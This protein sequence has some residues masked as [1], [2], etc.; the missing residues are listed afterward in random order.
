[1]NR[2]IYIQI[3]AAYCFVTMALF[4]YADH[5]KL[6]EFKQHY[7]YA[8]VKLTA[9]LMSTGIWSSLTGA[10]KTVWKWLTI[11]FLIRLIWQIFELEYYKAAN[12]PY[13]LD[14]LFV[15]C[16]GIVIIQLI[17]FYAKRSRNGRI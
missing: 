15:V 1:M 14:G 7:Y 10:I 12:K 3:L 16:V 4:L 17:I 13:V 6:A 8:W 2:N 5:G 9:L 11:F